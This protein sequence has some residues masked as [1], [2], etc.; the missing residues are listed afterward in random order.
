[1]Q[2][3]VSAHAPE[4]SQ[5][6][7]MELDHFRIEGAPKRTVSGSS[8]TC[9]LWFPGAQAGAA[10]GV[11]L[12]KDCLRHHGAFSH[13]IRLLAAF[14]GRGSGR[15]GVPTLWRLLG[16]SRLLSAWLGDRSSG[17]R[18]LCGRS[19]LLP[20]GTP[21]RKGLVGDTLWTE[22]AVSAS[23]PAD[24]PACSLAASSQPVCLWISN[25]PSGGLWCCGNAH[26]AV[27]PHQPACWNTLGST[28]GAGVVLLRG[29]R[30]ED[31]DANA[32][33]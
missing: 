3:Q 13:Q 23:R 25:H 22:S 31:S 24:G 11:K 14:P 12:K 20:D 6:H 10:I 4:A 7:W 33:F 30:R 2:A 32:A 21:A 29:N 27:L 19:D 5:F 9:S 17:S 26:G 16:P 1:M 28:H 18:Q 15:G 8:N